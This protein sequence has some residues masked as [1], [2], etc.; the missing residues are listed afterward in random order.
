MQLSQLIKNRGYSARSLQLRRLRYAYNRIIKILRSSVTNVPCDKKRTASV[1]SGKRGFISP[2]LPEDSSE[3]V[4]D[5]PLLQR[6]TKGSSGI[7]KGKLFSLSKS[8]KQW[9]MIRRLRRL[10][11]CLM[12]T[13]GPTTGGRSIPVRSRPRDIYRTRIEKQ[14]Y[15][16]WFDKIHM[17]WFHVEAFR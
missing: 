13:R 4:G 2:S 11:R 1:R 5:P 8:R 16:F 9:L 10:G 6:K 14:C 17:C 3:K 7:S 12:R 15:L